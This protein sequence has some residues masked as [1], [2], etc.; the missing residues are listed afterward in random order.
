MPGTQQLYP[1]KNA[2]VK[3]WACEHA[4]FA[5]YH[6]FFENFIHDCIYCA[7]FL[8]RWIMPC[9]VIFKSF[10]GCQSSDESLIPL[11]VLASL[12]GKGDPE[13][14]Q[15]CIVCREG[16]FCMVTPKKGTPCTPPSTGVRVAY[17]PFKKLSP[18]PWGYT[19]RILTGISLL[20]K[21]KHFFRRYWPLRFL[22]WMICF[23]CPFQFSCVF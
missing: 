9:E 11:S 17:K 19:E 16:S 18:P 10:P 3:L 4:M 12:L 22:L 5:P 1:P 6:L 2:S 20:I 14:A 23:I 8:S 13:E 15:G 21:V 7:Y